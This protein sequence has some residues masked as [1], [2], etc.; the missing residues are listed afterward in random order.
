M[1]EPRHGGDR[2]AAHS[3]SHRSLRST[4]PSHPSAD[5]SSDWARRSARQGTLDRSSRSGRRRRRAEARPSWRGGPALRHVPSALEGSGWADNLLILSL[6]SKK[7]VE[8]T[9]SGIVLS[10]LGLSGLTSTQNIEGL[11][12]DENG[13]IYLVAEQAQGAGAAADAASHLFVLKNM[14]PI[15]EP[16][17]IAMV[18]SGLALLGWR[19]R[20][21]SLPCSHRQTSRL[22]LPRGF[23]LFVVPRSCRT[24]PL[25]GRFMTAGRRD[26]IRRK[27][28][29]QG[30]VIT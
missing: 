21:S 10:S 7:L 5:P 27:Q 13:V 22:D 16:G 18:L 29:R 28:R 9:R 25:H 17:A 4:F 20:R 6:D 24:P 3:G 26:A 8:V 19:A 30:S 11:T 23:R 2:R 14:A 12:I 1:A 15:P